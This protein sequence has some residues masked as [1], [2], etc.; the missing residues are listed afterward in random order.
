MNGR[1]ETQEGQWQAAGVL[2]HES[3]GHLGM[4]SESQYYR[5]KPMGF[6]TT[7]SQQSSS[8]RTYLIWLIRTTRD[9]ENKLVSIL[10]MQR[11]ATIF[12]FKDGVR[13]RTYCI[14]SRAS[15]CV[16]SMPFVT[17]ERK[18]DFGGIPRT[19]SPKNI[20]FSNLLNAKICT[21][22]H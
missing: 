6:L 4:W 15:L 12:C 2:I 21:S 13:Q 14:G 17:R 20:C 1:P 19:I 9:L 22:K 18:L 10:H 7:G 16:D 8:Q 5:I 3:T 11:V